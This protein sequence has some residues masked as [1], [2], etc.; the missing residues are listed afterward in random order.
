MAKRE[1]T[2]CFSPSARTKTGVDVRWEEEGRNLRREVS[3]RFTDAH[4][5]NVGTFTLESLGAQVCDTR[6]AAACVSQCTPIIG[7]LSVTRFAIDACAPGS[8]T[9]AGCPVHLD[10]QLQATGTGNAG[11]VALDLTL[12]EDDQRV[13]YTHCLADRFGK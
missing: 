5:L 2:A 12:H 11:A 3:L 4:P 9:Q 8:R 6:C 10:G 13:A 7:T 1:S